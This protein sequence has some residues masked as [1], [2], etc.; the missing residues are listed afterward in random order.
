MG[1]APSTAKAGVANSPA[2]TMPATTFF[3]SDMCT[4][5]TLVRVAM[6]AGPKAE[7]TA[8]NATRSAA[9]NIFV[10]RVRDCRGYEG[11]EVGKMGNEMGVGGRGY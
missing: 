3:C 6:R 1:A 9:R 7:T 2:A 5:A 4:G 10:Y 8:R 11:V